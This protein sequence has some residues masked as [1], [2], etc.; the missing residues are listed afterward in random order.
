MPHQE[1]EDGWPLGLQPLSRRVGLGGNRDLSE[2]ISL[3]TWVTGSPTSSSVSSSDL[4]TQS[5]GS[6]FHENS[7]TLGNLLG[8]RPNQALPIYRTN[9][10]A[11]RK[12]YRSSAWLNMLIRAGILSSQANSPPSLGHFL[13]VERRAASTTKARK[14]VC[15]LCSASADA[16]LE[17]SSLLHGRFSVPLSMNN[18]AAV[19]IARTVHKSGTVFDTSNSKRNQRES[20]GGSRN[21]VLGIPM[22]FSCVCSDTT[23]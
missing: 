7:V 4:E 12:N 3:D 13:E 15:F 6:S 2:P 5:T 19:V 21:N 8:V 22:L 17:T 9:N 1:Q 14:S 10:L 18:R 11:T 20:C 23:L 16:V